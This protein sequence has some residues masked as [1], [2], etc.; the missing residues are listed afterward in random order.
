[1]SCARRPFAIECGEP[2][3]LSEPAFFAGQM[4]AV[5]GFRGPTDPEARVP[6]CGAAGRGASS[7]KP[8]T[9]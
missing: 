6:G 5:S 3:D 7:E 4:Q 8:A 9:R 2:S 1:M